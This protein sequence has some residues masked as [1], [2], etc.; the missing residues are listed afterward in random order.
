MF[1][2]P[3]QILV[4]IWP[5]HWN[6]FRTDASKTNIKTILYYTYISIHAAAVPLLF[7]FACFKVTI[8]VYGVWPSLAAFNTAYYVV[9]MGEHIH[10]YFFPPHCQGNGLWKLIHQ[11]LRASEPP[12]PLRLSLSLPRASNCITPA[13]ADLFSAPELGGIS[14]RAID[15]AELDSTRG[16][17]HRQTH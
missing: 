8:C 9:S 7:I 2:V 14:R 17:A 15:T 11:L 1:S 10:S 3:L 5:W 13:C 4:L 12:P 16:R 6:V